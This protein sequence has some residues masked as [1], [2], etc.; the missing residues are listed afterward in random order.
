[1]LTTCVNVAMGK[2]KKLTHCDVGLSRD[3]RHESLSCCARRSL[4][5]ATEEGER[6]V[7]DQRRYT[8]TLRDRV[9]ASVKGLG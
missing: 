5:T 3:G 2:N 9:P 7:L 4:E 1:M 6:G 8:E